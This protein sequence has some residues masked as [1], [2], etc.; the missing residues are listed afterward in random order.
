MGEQEAEVMSSTSDEKRIIALLRS[1]TKKLRLKQL[2]KL[3]D[4]RQ[5][6]FDKLRDVP[7]RMQKLTNRVRLL[8][9]LVDDYWAGRYRKVRWYSLAVGVAATLYFISPSDLIPDAIPGIGQLDDVLM[10]AIALRL[11]RRDLRDYC[12]Y[13]GLDPND[14]F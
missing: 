3:H 2:D 4:S 6:V 1:A 7:N 8:L 10:M 5:V 14:Y 9:D 11:I 12:E 13:K